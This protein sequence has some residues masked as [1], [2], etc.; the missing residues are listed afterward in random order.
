MLK[1]NLYCTCINM[2]LNTTG[3]Q[4]TPKGSSTYG[5]ARAQQK[6]WFDIQIVK[7]RQNS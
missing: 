5:G 6:F 2:H 1:I 3:T 4:K 7:R